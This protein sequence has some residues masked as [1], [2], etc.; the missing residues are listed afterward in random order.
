VIAGNYS[1]T[2]GNHGFIDTNGVITPIDVPGG[3]NTEVTNTNAAGEIVGQYEDSATDTEHGF[4]YNNGVF[5]TFDVPGAVG[6]LVVTGISASGSV[7]GNYYQGTDQFGFVGVPAGPT[8]YA[9]SDFYGAGNSDLLFQNTGGDYA[10]WQTNGTAVIGGGNVGSPGTGW[11]EIAT[12][13]F[14]TGN[15]SD[16]LFESSSASFALWD[17]NGTAVT[18]VATFGSPGAGFSFV[19]VGNFDGTGNGDILFE[20]TGGDYA[21]W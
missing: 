6:E 20:N 11:T 8:G 17:M 1:D 14:N 19:D 18:N 13:D 9:P 4:V 7:F 16:I 2:N 3:F 5:S 10:M 12:G 21:M 15:K